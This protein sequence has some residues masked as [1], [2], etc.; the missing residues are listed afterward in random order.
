MCRK[1]KIQQVLFNF[2]AAAVHFVARISAI[3]Y[4]MDPFDQIILIGE[5]GGGEGVGA[6]LSWHMQ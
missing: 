1:N 5:L 2:E 4:N 3:S 6:A